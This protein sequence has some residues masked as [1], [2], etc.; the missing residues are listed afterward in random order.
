MRLDEPKGRA[1]PLSL[2][3]VEFIQLAAAQ[4]N[5]CVGK[6]PHHITGHYWDEHM[7]H[8]DERRPDAAVAEPP[9]WILDGN[10][11]YEIVTDIA[12]PRGQVSTGIAGGSDLSSSAQSRATCTHR[13]AI[14]V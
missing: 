9:T 7:L 13:W 2:P 10:C 11:V 14:A 3:G 6:L 1:R 12:V 4:L 8:L 5:K